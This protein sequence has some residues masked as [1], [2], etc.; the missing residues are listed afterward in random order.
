MSICCAHF[1]SNFC[2]SSSSTYADFIYFYGEGAQMS[3]KIWVQINFIRYRGFQGNIDLFPKW[4]MSNGFFLVQKKLK[5]FLFEVIIINIHYS[6]TENCHFNR[7]TNIKLNRHISANA[8]QSRINFN[9]IRN[10]HH[11]H[12]MN[13]AQWDLHF[14][15]RIELKC[16][17]IENRVY[18]EFG[19]REENELKVISSNDIFRKENANKSNP[20]PTRYQADEH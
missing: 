18:W 5:Q 13:G 14:K 11:R 1:M 4:F 2:L 10:I 19:Q 7:K 17:F 8:W 9:Y 3:L 16:K 6:N 15:S 12:Q 20:N